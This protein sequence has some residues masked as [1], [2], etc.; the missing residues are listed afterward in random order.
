MITR[1]ALLKTGAAAAA[2]LQTRPTSAAPWQRRYSAKPNVLVIMVD[3]MREPVHVSQGTLDAKLPKIMG[4]RAQSV[5]FRNYYTAAS[6][7]EPSRATFVTGLYAHQHWV[8]I[9]QTSHLQAD[10]PTYGD[11]LRA[12][13][14][15]TRWIGKWHLSTD[16]SDLNPWGFGGSVTNDP[17][18]APA[19]GQVRD[20]QIASEFGS[21]LSGASTGTPWC[22]T[23]SFVNPHDIMWYPRFT[24]NIPAQSNPP[25]VFNTLPPN[26][27]RPADM[28]AQ[29]KPI[30]QRASQNTAN[31][32]FGLMRYAG[33]GHEDAW[34]EYQDLYLHLQS[35]VDTQVGQVLTS[36]N[37]SSHKDNTIVLFVS[38]HGEYVGSHGMRGKGAG[39][40]EEGINVPLSVYDPTGQWMADTA[41]T[42]QQL[43]N[44]VD[45]A[46]LLLT[47][48][49]GDNSWRNESAYAQLATRLDA[50]AIL[51]SNSAAGRSA[52]LSTTDE[53]GYEEAP[54]A[55]FA[56]NPAEH[57]IA[58]RNGT[59][60]VASYSHWRENSA[61][62]LTDGQQWEC[63]DYAAD[64]N[65]HELINRATNASNATF[66]SLRTQLD[67]AISS[68]LRAPLPAS[69]R[70]VQLKAYF[71]YLRDI[72][73]TIH[74][75]RM[76]MVIR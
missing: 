51:K 28:A 32:S 50:A 60:K 12:Q 24:E 29:S 33:S 44:S 66:N 75:A 39:I 36:L 26:F 18:G 62:I 45:V 63:Y 40:Y 48:G 17:V 47:L 71:Q 69:L 55:P 2:A 65:R 43:I 14:Y 49:R 52:I 21:W 73:G 31:A 4:L 10:F 9:T 72:G 20:P 35:M 46:P 19:Q 13:G 41:T 34:H 23:V 59:G 56:D 7:C 22:C 68:E 16:T 6:M 57:V 15:D 3:Q 30:L 54:S 11:M 61:E 38:D 5:R 42:R 1:R 53:P 70:P 37:A 25:A 67:A 64:G 8:L 76:P 58:Y 74:Q 27:E